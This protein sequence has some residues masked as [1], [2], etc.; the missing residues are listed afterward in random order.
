[1]VGPARVSRRH[2]RPSWMAV[3]RRS[4][5]RPPRWAARLQARVG[6]G[7]A[8]PPPVEPTVWPAHGL[9]YQFGLPRLVSAGRRADAARLGR[10][11]KGPLGPTSAGPSAAAAPCWRARPKR[12]AG[13]AGA[14]A[15]DGAWHLSA[16][17][18]LH[19]AV[20]WHTHQTARLRGGSHIRGVHAVAR[21]R[22]GCRCS[23]VE[24]TATGPTALTNRAVRRWSVGRPAATPWLD[25]H[26]GRRWR[27]KVPGDCS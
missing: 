25:S 8:S 24:E 5:R 9:L 27:C 10:R 22:T 7:S 15:L 20:R 21:R 23:W 1:V 13:A 18:L 17:P 14:S 6:S 26:L 3:S 12:G 11:R 2:E 4:G 19:C 16:A